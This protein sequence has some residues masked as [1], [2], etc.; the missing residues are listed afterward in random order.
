VSVDVPGSW[1]DIPASASVTNWNITP[2]PA[3][4]NVFY[5]LRFP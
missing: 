1:F 4:P 5:R 2:D 3:T